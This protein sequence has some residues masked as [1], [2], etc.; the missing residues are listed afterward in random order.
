[1]RQV[2]PSDQRIQG[3]VCT[4]LETEL[5]ATGFW[6]IIEGNERNEMFNLVY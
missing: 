2:T 3:P 1:M 4:G 6:A 5:Y